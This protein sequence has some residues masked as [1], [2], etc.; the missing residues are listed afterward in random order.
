LPKHVY[1]RRH[2]VEI[3]VADDEADIRLLLRLN[4]E[5]EGYRVEEAPGGRQA[6]D[7]CT[8]RTYDA[9]VIDQMMDD[10]MGMEVA[11]LLRER[12]YTAPLIL[13]SAFVAPDVKAEAETL[14]VR[15]VTKPDLPAL[16]VE[17]KRLEAPG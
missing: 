16:L 5:G 14:D 6:L 7:L 4:L 8:Q 17:L 13:F 9:V 15:T 12:G 3:L 10:L 2:A 1:V 11:R